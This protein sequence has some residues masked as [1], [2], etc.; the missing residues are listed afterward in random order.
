MLHA[1]KIATFPFF[2]QIKNKSVPFLPF[3]SSKKVGLNQAQR[4]N[5]DPR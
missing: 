3:F 4:I 1:L 5:H 2:F